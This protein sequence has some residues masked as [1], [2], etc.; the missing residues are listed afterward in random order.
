M[1]LTIWCNA[2]FA[3]GP[4]RRLEEGARGH[5]LILSEHGIPSILAPGG[6]DPLMAEADVV[7]GQPDVADCLRYRKPRWVHLTTAGFARYD[8]DA[9]RENFRERSAALTKSSAVFAEPAAEHALAMMLALDR[10]LLPNYRDQLTDRSWH[11]E[12]RRAASH[13]M[14]GRKVVLSASGTIGRRVAELLAPFHC[15]IYAVRRQTRSEVGVRVVPESDL[16]R[17]LALADHVVNVLPDSEATRHWVN[18]RR[19][20]CFRRGARLLQCRARIHRGPGRP[21]GGPARRHARRGLPRCDRAGAAPTGASPLDGAELLHHPSR[22]RGAQ[23]P[24]RGAGRNTSPGISPP[25][26]RGSP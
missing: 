13:L 15:E 5:R 3:A 12:G 1:G 24:G 11:M 18:A 25:L 10:Q 6:P 16:T 23:R 19:L 7:F 2:K 21:G 22:R 20:A 14:L 26:T 4:M 17:V 9:F 8:T